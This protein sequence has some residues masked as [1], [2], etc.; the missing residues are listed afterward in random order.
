MSR[1]VKVRIAV[2]VD[3]TGCW[4]ASG[5]LTDNEESAGKEAM[6]ICRDGVQDGEARYWLTATLEV[7]EER[8]V[9]ADLV[10]K[11]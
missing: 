8:T 10:E 4:S 5:W 9:E 1:T 6:D 2:A 3:K 11:E 7:P